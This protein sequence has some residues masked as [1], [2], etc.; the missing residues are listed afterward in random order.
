MFTVSTIDSLGMM[1][2]RLK[3]MNTG[4]VAAILPGC[5]GILHEFIVIHEGEELDL[6]DGYLDEADFKKNVATGG[7]KGCKLSPFACRINNARFSFGEQ[8][9]TPEKFLL[10]GNALHGLLYD[11]AFEVVE[12]FSDEEKATVLLQYSYRGTEKGY[13]FHYDCEVCYTLREKNSLTVATIII[14]RDK[15]LIPMQDGWHPYFS[16]GQQIDDLEL[17]FQSD[18]LV[19]L[20]AGLIPTGKLIPYREFN[21]IKRIGDTFFDHCFTLNFDTCQPLCVLRDRAIG[22]QLEISPDKT[23]PYLQIYTPTHR[24]SIAIENLS[25]APDTFNNGMGLITLS[26]GERKTFVTN[27]KISPIRK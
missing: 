7:F 4:T 21:S 6:I 1:I 24:K 23:Y 2:I 19:E 13:P 27:F 22:L 15:G 20:D 5:G 10:N 8:D 16:F 3:D 9:Y 12:S 17:E 14:N 11:C 26:A 18:K 25:A